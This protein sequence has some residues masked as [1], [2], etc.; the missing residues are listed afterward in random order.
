MTEL[1][2]LGRSTDFAESM[3]VWDRTLR[4]ECRSLQYIIWIGHCERDAKVS[5]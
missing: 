5:P 4:D 2:T 3:H 1:L